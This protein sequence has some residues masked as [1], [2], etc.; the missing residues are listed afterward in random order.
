MPSGSETV[1]RFWF[2]PENQ[3]D[4]V[5]TPYGP[6][7]QKSYTTCEPLDAI[8]LSRKFLGRVGALH[9]LTKPKFACGFVIDRRDNLSTSKE[10]L[11]QLDDF[12]DHLDGWCAVLEDQYTHSIVNYLD[13]VQINGNVQSRQQ[14]W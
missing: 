13:F 4:G 8:R 6:L 3:T 11:T 5:F 12:V 14:G 2:F 7:E 9:R 1:G 10:S